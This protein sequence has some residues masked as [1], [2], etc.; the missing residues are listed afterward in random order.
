MLYASVSK[1]FKSGGFNTGANQS[2]SY[3]PETVLAYEAGM[4]SQF[5]DGRA[6]TNVSTFFY[7]YSDLQLVQIEGFASAVK[8]AAKAEVFGGEVASSFILTDHFTVHAS[9]EYLSAEFKEF[10]SAD[11]RFLGLGITTPVDLSGNSLPS[12]PEFSFRIGADYS[13]P[14]SSSKTLDFGFDY[15]WQDEIFFTP[16]NLEL[17]KQESVGRLDLTAGLDINDGTW[18]VEVFGKNVTDETVRNSGE[19]TSF[20]LGSSRTFTYS[21]PRTFGLRLKYQFD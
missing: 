12:A 6:Q 14:I 21:P 11:G 18:R 20:I 1:G 2:T 9:V 7:D 15:Y 19:V 4:K 10:S 8:N 5:W 17:S 16:F 13:Q 3:E